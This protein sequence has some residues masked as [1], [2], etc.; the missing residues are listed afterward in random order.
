MEMVTLEVRLP[1]EI[2]NKASEILA[3][4]GLTMEDAL[5]LFLQ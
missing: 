4:Q 5:I 1:R 2:Y 3:R